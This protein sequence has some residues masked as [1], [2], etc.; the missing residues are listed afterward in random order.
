MKPY[1]YL[2]GLRRLAREIRGDETIHV[3][4]RPYGFH[5]GNAMALVAY[6]Y[7]LCEYLEDAGKGP[8]LKFIVSIND[9]EQD[10][11]DGPDYREYPYNIYPKHSSLQFTPDEGDC[12]KSIVDHWQ[13]IIERNVRRLQNR[14]SGISITF[15]KNSDLLKHPF[16]RKLLLETI[17]HPKIQ[18][19]IFKKHSQS[20]VLDNPIQYAGAICFRCKQAHGETTVTDKNLVHWECRRCGARKTADSKKFQ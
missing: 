17:R 5:A 3:G 15:V 2:R 14:F 20:K 4:I 9:W 11:L 19:D 18:A 16:A 10:S 6:P 13:P 8:H 7:L 12:C 1:L